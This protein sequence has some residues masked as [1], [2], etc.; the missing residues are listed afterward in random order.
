[1]FRVLHNAQARVAAMM[2]KLKT[3]EELEIM[4]KAN[5]IVAEFLLMLESRVKPG[6]TTWELEELAREHVAKNHVKAAFMGYRGYPCYLCT[7]INEEVVHGI[8]SKT[9]RLKEGD[10]LSVDFGVIHKG[11]FGDAARTYAVG[12]ISAQA[13]KLMDFT[14]QSLYKGIEMARVGNHLSDISVAIQE[15]VEAAGFSVVRAFVGH[16]IGKEMHEAPQVPNFI[17]GE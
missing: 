3:R 7:S 4:R 17:T 9:R 1:M 15:H 5:R 6:V 14:E 8:P 2:V 16:G 11:Y 10:I 12:K 13:R